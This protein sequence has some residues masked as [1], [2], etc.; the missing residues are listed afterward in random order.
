MLELIA[1]EVG[2][3]N[4]I[5]SLM[6]QYTPDFYC[7]YANIRGGDAPEYDNLRRRITSFEYNS[8]LSVA[9]KLGFDGYFQS[10]SSATSEY[11]PDF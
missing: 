7:E 2:A 10:L 9:E 8:V 5:L 6:G 11:T 3:E 4:V 1:N